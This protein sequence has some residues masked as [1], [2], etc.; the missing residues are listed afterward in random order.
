MKPGLI[1]DLFG[2]LARIVSGGTRQVIKRSRPW[3]P[4]LP[5]A[6][7]PCPLCTNTEGEIALPGMPR[8]WRLL[9][10]AYTPH[11]RHRLIIPETCWDDT[12]LQLVGGVDGIQDALN[13]ARL[14]TMDDQVEMAVFIHIGQL[15]GQNLG[16]AHWHLMEVSVQRPLM[17]RSFP[18]SVLVHRHGQFEIGAAGARAG[19]C[20]IGSGGEPVRFEAAT[21]VELAGAL[22]W[23]ITRG[24][25]R[26]CSVEGKPP[27]FLVTVRI[28][29]DAHLR[30]AT[31]CPILTCWGAPEYVIATLEG[32]PITLPWPHEVTAA[33]LRD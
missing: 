8:G 20:L 6:P 26:F 22:E 4:P 5:R 25:D 29:P 12:R 11:Q 23:I 7:S 14:A 33:H 9:P 10:P 1:E 13:V 24:N 21:I 2:G 15:A 17:L 18:P 16:H 28:S 30:Y 32:G 3:Q 31:Y 27:E 19:E